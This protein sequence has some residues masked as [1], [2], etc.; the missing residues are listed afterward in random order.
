LS[1]ARTGE[2]LARLLAIVPW[3]VA[4]DG[5]RLSEVS[6][7]FGV[8]EDELVDDL[9]LLFMCGVYPFTPDSLVEVDI[10]GG[11][12]WVRFAD[13]FRRPVRLTAPEG[14]VLLAAARAVLGAP[15]GLPA[16]GTP[17]LARA[18]AKLEA[19]LGPGLEGAMEVTPGTAEGEFLTLLRAAAEG[20]RKV[21]LDYYSYG[22]DGSAVR[23]VQPWRVFSA[24]GHWY[25]LGWC[26]MVEGRR[27]F[28]VDRARF[29]TVL[30]E[31]FEP[32][33]DIGPL[34]VYEGAPE[35]PL[36]V[37]DLAPEA[38]WVIERYPHEGA[39]DLGSGRTRVRLRASSQAWL[40]RLL[41]RAGPAATVVSGAD[42][43]AAG[44]ARRVL[45]VY[46]RV[47]SGG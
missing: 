33:R 22:R 43:V 27:L 7:R 1:R 21:E 38:A 30:D 42:G 15:G 13:W 4:Q 45:A 35:D 6:E 40:E 17:A 19:A 2:R 23:V 3:V 31:S 14:L 41:L 18:V 26:E 20:R 36:V 34:D 29:V 12:V 28:R 37:L 5:P 24:E 32:P 46:G 10:E 11:R 8:P 44:A 9:N 25:L 47:T 39:E 16:S